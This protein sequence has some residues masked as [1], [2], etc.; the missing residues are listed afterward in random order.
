MCQGRK[1]KKAKRGDGKSKK[2]TR[3][4][5]E[6]DSDGATSVISTTQPPPMFQVHTSTE[7]EKN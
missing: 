5:V 6:R 4:D 7:K 3:D 2:R 1:G